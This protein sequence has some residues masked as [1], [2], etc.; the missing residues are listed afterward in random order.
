MHTSYIFLSAQ[1]EINLPIIDSLIQRS[2]VYFPT[3]RKKFYYTIYN[4][5]PINL[6]YDVRSH[7]LIP[8]SVDIVNYIKNSN[9][10]LSVTTIFN[11]I[12]QNIHTSPEQYVHI[13]SQNEI[14]VW[15]IPP[16]SCYINDQQNYVSFL[17]DDDRD[18]IVGY[19][20]GFIDIDK[21]GRTYSRYSNIEIRPDYR[22]QRLCTPFSTFS[23]RMVVQVM[24]VKYFSIKVAAENK[25]TACRCYVQASLNNNFCPYLNGQLICD[26]EQCDIFIE[27]PD[28]SV[29]IIADHDLP[30]DDSM[31]SR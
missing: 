9:S 30:Y 3:I 6:Y 28:S 5:C 14:Q 31:G 7:S 11:K 16:I 15:K 20:E 21:K 10:L 18:I 1:N 4:N 24:K 2:V 26:L 27:R 29:I 19:Y 22:G 13:E 23:Y 25:V 12:M 8:N 17:I